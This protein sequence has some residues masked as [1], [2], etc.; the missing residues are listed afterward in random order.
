VVQEP[1]ELAAAV[2][3]IEVVAA[4]DVALADEDLRHRRAAARLRQHFLPPA[5]LAR[6]LE[7]GE[8]DALL[9]E[10]F[11]GGEA[12]GAPGLGVDE[13]VTGVIGRGSS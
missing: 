9:A 13:M 6:D 7:L 5:R 1:V 4:A 10:E 11:L 12:I 3:G 2:E 8:L